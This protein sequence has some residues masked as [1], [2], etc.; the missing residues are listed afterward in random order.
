MYLFAAVEGS[1]KG[2]FKVYEVD[3]SCI[4]LLIVPKLLERG[5][6][7]LFLPRHLLSIGAILGG[8]KTQDVH[9]VFAKVVLAP[10]GVSTPPQTP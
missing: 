10:S 5:V 6:F 1:A 9:C 3:A 4:V 2:Y 7:M 8:G